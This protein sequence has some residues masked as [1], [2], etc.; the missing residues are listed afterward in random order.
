[1]IVMKKVV[2]LAVLLCLFSQFAFS[3]ISD[4][5][6]DKLDI[7]DIYLEKIPLA[8]DEGNIEKLEE[9][10][11][12]MDIFANEL[13]TLMKNP[14]INSTVSDEAKHTLVKWGTKKEE[15]INFIA[16]NNRVIVSPKSN[17][18]F[19][20]DYNPQQGNMYSL[21][22]DSRS[23]F[24][25]LTINH[26]NQLQFSDGTYGGLNYQFN[27]RF[28]IASIPININ[29]VG[30]S[31]IAT[32]NSN[33]NRLETNI[34]NKVTFFGIDA[35]KMDSKLNIQFSDQADNRYTDLGFDFTKETDGH[36]L[37]GN[38]D[39]HN[40][41]SANLYHLLA[42]NVDDLTEY[43]LIGHTYSY[44][45]EFS[46][47]LFPE[48][49][50]NSNLYL[51]LNNK[52]NQTLYDLSSRV[53]Y[54]SYP[55][56]IASSFLALYNT[57]NFP[58][59]RIKF[60]GDIKYYPESTSDYIHLGLS[61]KSGNYKNEMNYN[62]GADVYSYTIDTYSYYQIYMKIN[63]TNYGTASFFKQ[64]SA[65]IKRRQFLN[66]TTSSWAL[67]LTDVGD[68]TLFKDWQSNRYTTIIFNKFDNASALSS[69]N[70]SIGLSLRNKT[71]IGSTTYLNID[72]RINLLLFFQNYSMNTVDFG[73]SSYF[74][75]LF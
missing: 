59:T 75:F 56:K 65:Q 41:I 70:L 52:L 10:S 23:T 22:I 38:Y 2:F 44:S 64:L 47:T 25:D 62:Y 28:N 17:G 29:L 8:V 14:S 24:G 35:I 66:T 71:L 20:L 1:M 5:I 69:D 37:Q 3:S 7:I 67:D 63:Y 48:N 58:D 40:T 53:V 4:E 39:F 27:N 73:L 74:N 13:T 45:S 49:A 50:A 55:N 54:N 19:T 12:I 31:G 16:N 30:F 6:T 9:I 68:M 72:T 18:S 34:K 61:Q 57:F 60:I 46:Y 21:L 42:L 43:E 36:I 11:E 33:F 26:N 51:A 15:I 32:S